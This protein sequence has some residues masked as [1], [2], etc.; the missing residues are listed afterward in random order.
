[1]TDLIGKTFGAYQLIE[2][3]GAGGMAVVYKAYQPGLDRYAAVKILHASFS[4]EEQFVRRFQREARA[5]TKLEHAH[6]LPIYDHG[7]QDGMAYLVMRYIEAGT[8]RNRMT[9]GK[10]FD[11]EQIN[12]IIGQ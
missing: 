3:I 8:L 10:P 12:H 9:K 1:M 2:Q 5:V 7:Q 11:L 6:I 4:S